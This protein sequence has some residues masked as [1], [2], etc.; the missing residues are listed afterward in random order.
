MTKKAMKVMERWWS[1]LII[2]YTCIWDMNIAANLLALPHN[3]G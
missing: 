1:V 2:E 3:S